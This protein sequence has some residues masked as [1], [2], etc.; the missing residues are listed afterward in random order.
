M[1]ATG[2]DPTA[3]IATE[4]VRLL[5]RQASG[6]VVAVAIGGSLIAAVLLQAGI[7]AIEVLLWTLVFLLVGAYRL[8]YSRRLMATPA[9]LGTQPLRHFLFFAVANGLWAGAL[10]AVFFG[11]LPDE[12]N[13]ALTVMVVLSATGTAGTYG[14]YPAGLLSYLLLSVP[15]L[16]VWWAGHGG[17]QSWLIAVTLLLYTAV[18]ARFARELAQVFERSVTIR[19]EREQL[20]QQLQQEKLET[21]RA[22]RQAEDANL[23]KS[24]F[25]ANASHDLRQPA[26]TLGLYTAVLQRTAETEQHRHIARNIAEASRVLGEL[27]D[28]LLDV[29]RLD[30]GAVDV[31]AQMVDLEPVLH[32]LLRETRQLASHKPIDIELDAASLATYTDPVLLQRAL[33]NLLHNAVKFT[34][35][36]R[37]VLRARAVHGELQLQVEDSGLGIAPEH[38]MLVFEEFYQVGNPERDRVKGLGLGLSIVARLIRLLGGEITLSSTPG[39]GSIFTLRLPHAE[40]GVASA[41]APTETPNDPDLR[42]HRVLVVDDDAMVRNGMR[43]TLAGWGAEVD[44]ADGLQQALALRDAPGAPRWVLCLCDLR[45]RAGENGIHTA[46]ALQQRQPGLPVLLITGD[47][48]AER[49][50]EAAGSGLP[51]LHKPLPAAR[52]AE[53]VHRSLQ[54]ELTL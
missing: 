9:A 36:G 33:R 28:N 31:R 40:P 5:A 30:A 22:R 32:E 45:L 2:A 19:F 52:L 16:I 11:R 39:R 7:P 10:P 41:A 8:G 44:V 48:A 37:I 24:R 47:T 27:L 46:T 35:R 54:R 17:P 15:P 4:R 20:I 50:A 14:C 49:I 13:F 18:M 29:S 1:T 38:Q 51:L 3:P 26:H 23:A 25:L 53:L 43:D 6:G 42:G 21:E 12:A 34:D